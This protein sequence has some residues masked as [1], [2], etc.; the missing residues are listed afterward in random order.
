[1][2]DHQPTLGKALRRIRDERGWTLKEMSRQSGIPF[3]TLAKVEHDR[4]S[5]S[6]D[7]IMEACRRLNMSMADLL[8]DTQKASPPVMTG[9]RSI[10][11][12]DNALRIRTKNYDYYYLCPDLRHKHM[13]PIFS[14]IQAKTLEDFGPLVRHPGEECIY[15]VKGR[16]TIHTDVYAPLTLETGEMLYLD[17]NMGHAYILGPDCDEAEI[18]GVCYEAGENVLSTFVQDHAVPSGE[19][20]PTPNTALPGQ[21][22]DGVPKRTGRR[23]RR[24]TGAR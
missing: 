1:M 10:G 7:K 12:L 4:L 20:E 16:V 19:A 22:L 14:R 24:L 15:V 5:L 21:D 23:P 18:I 13:L 2:T 17:A 11:R 3:S 9:R 6:Y 8:I